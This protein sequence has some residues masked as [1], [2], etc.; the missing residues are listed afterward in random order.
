MVNDG[1]EAGMLGGLLDSNG[2]PFVKRHRGPGESV[3][4]I[5]GR[6]V[7]GVDILVGGRDI[8]KARELLAFLRSK[9]FDG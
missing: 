5:M 3:S 2:I 8:E 9:A 7:Y 4:I 1:P 6:S